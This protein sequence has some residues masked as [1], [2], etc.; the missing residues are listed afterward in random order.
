MKAA[1]LHGQVPPDAPKDEQDVLVE[2]A[3]VS[4]ALGRFGYQAVPIPFSLDLE[5]VGSRLQGLQPDFVFNL[6]ESVAGRGQ[7]IHLAPALLDY[8]G[9][10]YTGAKTEAMFVTS[11]KRLAKR[12]LTGAGI[13]TPPWLTEQDITAG[14]RALADRYIVKS[15]WEHASIGIAQDSVVSK[16]ESLQ[17]LLE[18]RR[19][20]FGGEWFAEAYIEG[21]EFN[22][23]LLAG[24]DGPD[25]LPPAEIR[26]LGYGEDRLKI[27]DYRAKWDP[28]TYEYHHTPR[29]FDFPAPDEPLLRVLQD[30]ALAC[31][32]LFDLRG[33][34]RVDFRVDEEGRPWVLEV[35]TNPCLAPDAGF[36]AAAARASL[37]IDQVVERIIQDCALV[38][39]DPRT[40]TR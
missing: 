36:L 21:R 5:S 4:E 10:P 40:E 18:Q 33:Y 7:L 29:R 38:R 19:A 25:V 17:H 1:I 31:W 8:L 28:E 32:R 24:K 22:L 9:L 39:R 15:V 23:S 16:I 11:N 6:V 37:G 30:T 14:E 35:N 34:A 13:A 27:V 26:F 20:R 12:L 3:V 2:V